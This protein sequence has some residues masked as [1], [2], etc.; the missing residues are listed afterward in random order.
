MYMDSFMHIT[1]SSQVSCSSIKL[2][3]ILILR[4]GPNTKVPK[5]RQKKIEKKNLMIL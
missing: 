5:V 1:P 4:Q 3:T 2:K